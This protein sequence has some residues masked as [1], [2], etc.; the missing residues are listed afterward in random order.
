MRKGNTVG[1]E[2]LIAT[3]NSKNRTVTDGHLT[4][5]FSEV[6]RDLDAYLEHRKRNLDRSRGYLFVN[7]FRNRIGRPLSDRS[8]STII[9]RL[10]EKSGVSF[11]PLSSAFLLTTMS[12]AGLDLDTIRRMMRHSSVETTLRCYLYADPRKMKTAIDSVNGAFATILLK[13][14]LPFG[15]KTFYSSFHDLFYQGMRRS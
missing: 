8:L 13:P 10:V 12:G 5:I 15:G 9:D 7:E 2:V 6:G 14:L 3:Y 11:S 1:D 4:E